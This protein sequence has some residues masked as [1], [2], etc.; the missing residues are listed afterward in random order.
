MSLRFVRPHACSRK[1]RCRVQGS[2]PFFLSAACPGG[3][4]SEVRGASKSAMAMGTPWNFALIVVAVVTHAGVCST[5][6]RSVLWHLWQRSQCLLASQLDPD[7]VEVLHSYS[8]H[9]FLFMSRVLLHVAFAALLVCI[10]TGSATGGIAC[11]L[12]YAVAW[13]V[14]KGSVKVGAG[15]VKRLILLNYICM[16]LRPLQQGWPMQALQE[17]DVAWRCVLAAWRF[18]NMSPG[19]SFSPSQNRTE[20]LALMAILE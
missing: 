17:F 12:M 2:H 15:M 11:I 16:A 19:V 13:L 3:G 5:E 8:E 10:A 18:W 9:A 14:A 1:S 7:Y 20:I 4:L 6:I